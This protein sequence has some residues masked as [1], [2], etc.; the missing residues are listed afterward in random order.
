MRKHILHRLFEPQSIAVVGASERSGSVGRQVLSNITAGG[1]EGDIYPVNRN[2]DTIQGLASYDSIGDIDHPI[3]LAVLAIPA[4]DVPDA[5]R[6]CGERQVGAVVVISAGFGEVGTP[7]KA[8]EN[9]IVDLARTY[10][11]PLVGPNCL[12]IMRQIGRAHV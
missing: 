10:Q 1:F 4:R 9:E 12:G 3:D 8:L 5:M 6:Q 11:I 7:G 2:Y